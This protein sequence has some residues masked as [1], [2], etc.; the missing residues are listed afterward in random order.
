MNINGK[1]FNNILA[2]RIQEHIKTII[3][4]DQV[5]FIAGMQCWFNIWKS[6]NVIHYRNT[7]L[8]KSYDHLLSEISRASPCTRWSHFLSLSA[9]QLAS[10][11]RPNGSPTRPSLRQAPEFL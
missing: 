4:Q 3:H 11:A 7:L 10:P 9:H 6:I 2:I 8:K 1:R 5:G